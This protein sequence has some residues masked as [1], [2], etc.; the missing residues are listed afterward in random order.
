MK[1]RRNWLTAEENA[2][3][4]KHRAI[5]RAAGERG[6]HE[7]ANDALTDALAVLLAALEEP[8]AKA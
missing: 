3:L 1:L 7:A 5:A 4:S 6:D 8:D 2:E